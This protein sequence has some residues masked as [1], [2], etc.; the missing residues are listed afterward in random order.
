MSTIYALDIRRKKRVRHGGVVHYAAT[1]TFHSENASRGLLHVKPFSARCG[2]E[3]T[4]D[5]TPAYLGDDDDI[6][7]TCVACASD[8]RRTT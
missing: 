3:F 6:V 2:V 8:R 4:G 7:V 5:E 1:E